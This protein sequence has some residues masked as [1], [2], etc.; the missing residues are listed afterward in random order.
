MNE[1]ATVVEEAKKVLFR[2]RPRHAWV[3]IRKFEDGETVTA[4]GVVL[5]EGMK[6][7]LRAEVV[8]FSDTVKDLKVGSIVLYTNFPIDIDDVSD[9]TGDNNLLLVRDE[10]V[11]C[12]AIPL[13]AAD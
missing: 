13:D 11:Y 9:L 4:G 3:L 5:P 6:R 10:E 2:L 12:E 1:T 7:Q 8:A